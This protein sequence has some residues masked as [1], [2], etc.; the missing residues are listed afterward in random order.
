VKHRFVTGFAEVKRESSVFS[1]KPHRVSAC[2][3]GRSGCQ[4][5]IPSCVDF[6]RNR[7]HYP[8]HL[9][10]VR[11]DKGRVWPSGLNP[12]RRS[13]VML[14]AIKRFVRE[15]S[16]LETVE[17]AIVGGL[18]VAVGAI[19]FT[20]IGQDVQTSLGNMQNVTAQAAAASGS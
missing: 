5:A 4:R 2:A 8:G 7:A 6:F 9:V 1:P 3:L 14:N 17:W 13:K 16:G 11:V 10:L 18:V 15:E 19:I 20:L 12:T